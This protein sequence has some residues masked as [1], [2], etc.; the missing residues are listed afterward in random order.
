MEVTRILLDTSAYSAYARGNG[1]IKEILQEVDEVYLTP[2]I[3]GELLSGFAGGRFET[4]NRDELRR[5]RRSPRVIIVTIDEETAERFA[6]ILH[7]LRKAGTPIPTND[8]WI[9]A[10]A[11]QYGL[12]IVT[13]DAHF[14]HIPHVIT[15]LHRDR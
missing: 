2:V 5:F 14:Q 12:K 1:E 7:A 11:M 3:L 8:L 10:C 9:A 15:D 13:F 4:R 6:V